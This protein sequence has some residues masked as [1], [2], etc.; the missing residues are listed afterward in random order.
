MFPGGSRS[1]EARESGP[2]APL[3]SSG[4]ASVGADSSFLLVFFI[5]FP[6]LSFMWVPHLALSASLRYPQGVVSKLTDSLPLFFL[7]LGMCFVF[8]V[9]HSVVVCFSVH[10]MCS[11]RC[12][13]EVKGQPWLSCPRRCPSR[14]L[15]MHMCRG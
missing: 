8:V 11:C 13:W 12:M 2:S 15:Q 9:V 3:L 5:F 7:C 14:V 6:S 4:Q 10:S 1:Y